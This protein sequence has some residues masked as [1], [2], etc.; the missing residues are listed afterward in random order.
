MAT[1]EG[2]LMV[3]SAEAVAALPPNAGADEKF[4]ALADLASPNDHH[5]GAESDVTPLRQ[6]LAKTHRAR[7]T[8]TRVALVDRR[9]GKR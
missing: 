7:P 5:F 9:T 2:F 6:P 3:L 8:S 4:L 1:S